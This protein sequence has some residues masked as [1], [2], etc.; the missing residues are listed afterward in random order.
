MLPA[1]AWMSVESPAEIVIAPLV[2]VR[3]A[4]LPT[5]AAT[6]LSTSLIEIAPAPTS[7]NFVPPLPAS[8]PPPAIVSVSIRPFAS[9]STTTRCREPSR[10][11]RREDGVR[12][13]VLRGRDAEGD[14]VRAAVAVADDRRGATVRLD[15]GG[16]DGTD[17][18][19][20]AGRVDERAAGD[21]GLDRVRDLVFGER[22]GDR[23][24]W[25][26]APP[27]ERA[28]MSASET[29]S[30]STTGAVSLGA[31]PVHVGQDRVVHG[32]LRGCPRRSRRRRCRS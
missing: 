31:G 8:A 18:R 28:K 11:R 20:A 10:R 17:P 3:I 2:A 25:E 29:A 32:V 27:I 5:L 9:A 30:T 22:A 7:A 13:R 21:A 15:R 14:P 12:D 19:A 24:S 23:G 4:P 26:K 1:S 16:V 6:E